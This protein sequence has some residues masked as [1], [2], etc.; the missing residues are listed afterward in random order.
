MGKY[1]LSVLIGCASVVLFCLPVHGKTTLSD[2]E[3]KKE[4][5]K[6]RN[7]H[8]AHFAPTNSS[9]L[10]ALPDAKEAAATHIDFRKRFR[11]KPLRQLSAKERDWAK[12]NFMAVE[13]LLAKRS[14][15]VVIPL[16]I[17]GAHIREY[18]GASA[19]VVSRVDAGSMAAGKLKA[20]DVIVGAYGALFPRDDD[21]RMPLGYALAESQ[22]KFR[23]G[24]LVLDVV[25]NE[26]VMQVSIQTGVVDE[27]SDTRPYDCER[28]ER[29][30][31]QAM[32]Y[33]IDHKPEKDQKNACF[34]EDLFLMGM[35]DHEALETVRRSLYTLGDSK[36]NTASS[37]YNAYRLVTLCE[38]Y[39]LT[40]D[41]AVLDWARIYVDGL[42]NGQMT[43][44][45]WSHSCPPGGYGAVNQVGLVCWMGLVLAR[46]AGLGVDREVLLRSI[47]FFG[48]SVGQSPPY[49]DHP[50]STARYRDQAYNGMNATLAI[51]LN[52]LGASDLAN[53]TA[54]PIC[55]S[56]RTR[57]YGHAARFGISWG[58]VGASLA[59]KPEFNLYMNNLLWYYE[60][61]RQSDGSH[62]PLEGT[63]APPTTDVTMAYGLSKRKL[64]IFGAPRGVF[65]TR[66]PASLVEAKEHFAAKRWKELTGFLNSYTPAGADERRLAVELM[67]AY[68]RV[69]EHYRATVDMI[70]SNIKN[71]KLWKASQQLQALRVFIGS[72]RPEMKVLASRIGTPQK[73][74]EPKKT[75]KPV[76]TPEPVPDKVPADWDIVLEG[77]KDMWIC[78]DMKGTSAPE[79]DWMALNYEPMAGWEK[80]AQ[81]SE[82][83]WKRS[84]VP[85][86][87]YLRL[88]FDNEKDAEKEYSHLC[89]LID[90]DFYGD[91]FLNGVRI[92]QFGRAW[93]ADKQRRLDVG[94]KAVA[95]LR[96][97]RNLVAMSLART[98]PQTTA[99]FLRTM[100]VG[101]GPSKGRNGSIIT[102]LTGKPYMTGDLDGT[103]PWKPSSERLHQD[104]RSFFEGKSEREC[105]RF[106]SHPVYTVIAEAAEAMV[107]QG[108]KSILPLAQ[109][110]IADSNAEI[111]MGGWDVAIAMQKA[112]L[113]DAKSRAELLKIA[114]ADNSMDDVTLQCMHRVLTSFRIENRDAHKIATKMAGSANPGTRGLATKLFH[115]ARRVLRDPAAAIKVAT[116]A[117]TNWHGSDPGLINS[118]WSILKDKD[119]IDHPSCKDLIPLIA[120][121]YDKLVNDLRGMH[122][123]GTMLLGLPVL[124]KYWSPETEKVP[125]LVSGLAKSYIKM[126]RKGSRAYFGGEGIRWD[127]ARNQIKRLLYTLTPDA[128]ASLADVVKEQQIWFDNITPREIT[129]LGGKIM[130]KWMQEDIHELKLW[131]QTLRKFERE[132][133]DQMLLNM[134]KSEDS[135]KRKV[136]VSAAWAGR[137]KDP[138]NAIQIA[139]SDG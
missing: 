50:V 134:A 52:L 59:H 125:H 107:K 41:A 39:F 98:R 74:E 117:L 3:L 90:A 48:K 61:A 63:F 36:I 24:Q 93:E 58:A 75:P 71:A 103:A 19:V 30:A 115:P 112:N 27:Y 123:S 81:L 37:W 9:V 95:L 46:E 20:G 44:G 53:W 14:G 12:R 101:L 15:S 104:C 23:K 111:R 68:Q 106:L 40:G 86:V 85:E 129:Q 70:E 25:R 89:L 105:A 121:V 13:F 102:S 120:L 26:E 133:V 66:V 116:A 11:G 34:Y 33:V 55:Y 80:V 56:Y 65:G 83:R 17:T 35:D 96:P 7:V 18:D 130:L 8:Q 122:S 4:L 79:G 69:E 114:A 84:A 132:N 87:V 22:S 99:R 100:Q 97:G 21:T 1:G 47:R 88:A 32:R 77:G 38:Y 92:M 126:P 54:R 137:C 10:G 16:G 91:V 73:P 51:T 119:V 31:K 78:E 72:E 124:E 64:R 135:L 5:Q 2:A 49:G 82:Q 94:Q 110:L 42:E 29:I 57:M 139:P 128:A 76:V 109:R 127:N 108:G 60:I 118:A 136:A 6:L 67:A 131:A 138:K 43:C 113:L 28:S 45:S 62:R